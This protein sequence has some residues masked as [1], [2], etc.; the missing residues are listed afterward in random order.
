[1]VSSNYHHKK[2]YKIQ[3]TSKKTLY[4]SLYLTLAFALVELIGGILSSSLSLVGD[5]FHM[6]SDV[7]ALGSSMIALYFST[8]KPNNRFTFGYL[9]LEIIVAFLNG[10][11][12]DIIA[13]GILIEGLKRMIYP[14]SIEFNSM[15]TISVIGLIVNILITYILHKSLEEENN[16][17]VQSAMWHFLG[18]LLNSVGVIFA[19]II[20]YFTNFI[21]ID[22][23]MSIIISIVI[24]KG[25][26]KILKKSFLILMETTPECIDVDKLKNSILNLEE[27]ISIHELHIWST[28]SE[29]ITLTMHILL[30]EYDVYN[31]YIIINK[32]TKILNEYGIY[33]ITIQIENE[34]I[35][36]HLDSD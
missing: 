32:L 13:I 15:F 34:N 24:F 35:N 16:L 11:V 29:E 27:I 22:S 20:I 14:V 18:D 10:L 2:H 33:H 5:S 28:D 30:K 12:L 21:Y 36:M 6:F 26:Y 23:I 19:S 3:T 4:F 7:V 17:N 9:R 8:K 31:N 1:M 25:G